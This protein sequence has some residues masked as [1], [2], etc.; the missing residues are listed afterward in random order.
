MQEP[1][2]S[3]PECREGTAS[4]SDDRGAAPASLPSEGQQEEQPLTTL[5]QQAPQL[6]AMGPDSPD[7]HTSAVMAVPP[8]ASAVASSGA[9]TINNSSSARVATLGVA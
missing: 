2:E 8:D 4:Y 7:I 5:K 3:A 9:S 1:L 6:F